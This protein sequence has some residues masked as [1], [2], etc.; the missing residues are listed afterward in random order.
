MQGQYTLAQLNISA[1]LSYQ[2]ILDC[3]IKGKAGEHGICEA[4]LEVPD[5]IKTSQVNALKDSEAAVHLEGTTLL[6]GV[7]TQAALSSHNG[8]HRVKLVIT[9][10]SI[11]AD[12]DKDSC[13]YQDP[14]KKLSDMVSHALSGTGV[15]ARY[16]K[17]IPIS[18]VVY[19]Q[20]ETPWQFIKRLAAQ[21]KYNVYPDFKSSTIT[22]GE[23]ET[24]TYPQSDLGQVQSVNKDISELRQI[25]KNQDSTAAAYAYETQSYT[26][27][28]LAMTA[29]EHI[30]RETILEHLITGEKGI[31]QNQI[32]V[33][34]T[35]CSAPSYQSQAAPA[36]AGG[37]VTG[38]VTAVD[39]NQ[40]Q[41]QFDAGGGIG[42]GQSWL[43]YESVLSN[44]FYCMPDVGD[45]AFIYY[46]NNGK[47]ICMGSKRTSDATRTTTSRKKKS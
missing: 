34:K 12:K 45:K 26:S 46:E 14:G 5:T 30:G 28:N 47:I 18:H 20:N 33:K 41:V 40:I 13:V 3:R 8:Y 6:Q 9:T 37:I 4:L 42:G 1:G 15:T 23:A 16:E 22:I 43:P 19:R 21:Y 44:S 25:Q 10:R 39:G 7:I 35:S 27:T 11:L 29:G 17:D 36:I 31:L 2:T 32:Q 24:A 38:T